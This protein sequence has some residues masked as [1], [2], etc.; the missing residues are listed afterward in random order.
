MAETIKKI[1]K[2]GISVVMDIVG[3]ASY[4][5]GLTE[6]LD[7]IYAP[8][9]AGMIYLLYKDERWAAI[10]LAEEALPYTDIIPSAT[11]AWVDHYYGG[12]LQKA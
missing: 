4:L 1:G 7:L 10:A 5:F 3:T 2:L 11:L 6:F 12:I 8:I 9:Q